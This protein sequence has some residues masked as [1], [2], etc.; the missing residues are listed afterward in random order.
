MSRSPQEIAESISESGISKVKKPFS[1]LFALSFLAGVYI[2]FG[3]LMMTVVS[4]DTSS[5][6]GVGLTSLISGLV[7]SLGLI[8]VVIG[9]AELF[10]GNTLITISFLNGKINLKNLARNWV[11]VYFGNF[12]GSLFI[13]CLLF[14][15]A[16][17]LVNNGTLGVRAF[18]IASGKITINPL[19]C[20]F[21]G[22]LANWLVCL[23][24]WLAASAK[25]T[26]GKISAVIFPITAFVAAG[27]EHSVANMYIIPAGVVARSIPIVA[28]K[29]LNYPEITFSGF[30][31]N[32]ISVTLG[33]IIGG[34]IFVGGIY[35]FIYLKKE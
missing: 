31:S 24:V 5:F 34:A 3:G 32:M 4:Q 29:T 33:N 35:W 7:F 14:F 10:T 22:I 28:E 23:G 27:F 11:I 19:T 17:F 30:V 18:V 21:R 25:D 6:I 16:T 26:L 15:S 2:S 8:L 12:I 9:G 1:K 20:F 13:V